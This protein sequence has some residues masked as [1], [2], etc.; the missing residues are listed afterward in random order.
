[1][2]YNEDRGMVNSVEA[3]QNVVVECMRAS[4]V[5]LTDKQ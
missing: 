1:M 2:V 4:M 5:S 3:A